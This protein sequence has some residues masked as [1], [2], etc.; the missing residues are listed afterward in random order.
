[1]TE[2]ILRVA[3]ICIWASALCPHTRGLPESLEA[4]AFKIATSV[5]PA[6]FRCV[7]GVLPKRYHGAT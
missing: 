3:M 5:T 2:S 6:P 4:Q 1:M 7:F